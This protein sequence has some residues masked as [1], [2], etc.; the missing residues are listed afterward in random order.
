MPPRKG[1]KKKSTKAALKPPSPLASPSIVPEEP[2]DVAPEQEQQPAD[3][4]LEPPGEPIRNDYLHSIGLTTG[5]YEPMEAEHTIVVEA[6]VQKIKDVAEASVDFVESINGEDLEKESK[7]TMEERKAKME[8]LRAK[9]RT[10]SQANRASLIEEA[11]KAKTSARDLARLEKQ[12]KLAEMLRTKADAEERGEDV[13]REKN[14]EWTIEE[15]E[16]WES[17]LARKARRADFEFHDDA[18][19]ARRRYKKDLDQIKP[20]LVSYNKQKEVAMGLAPGTLVTAFNP[21]ASSSSASSSAMQVV[22]T[23]QQQQ[24]AADNLYRDANSMLYGD[25]KPSEDAIDR[26]VGKINKD[27][28]K[29]GKFSRKRLNED[30]GDITYINERNRV[31]N[32]KIAR[33]YDKY[34]SE[35][36]ASFER[37]TAL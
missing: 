7:V 31:F 17:K 9:M 36:R 35:I 14:W 32:K 33:Y 34:T 28:D 3:V 11:A 22:P 15:N 27:I 8:Q 20:D 10:S 2:K 29:K 21:T 5:D 24:L 19:A 30:E 4:Q 1:S 23:S 37:G 18:H 16:A 26:V 13:E 25:N 6:A 12:R